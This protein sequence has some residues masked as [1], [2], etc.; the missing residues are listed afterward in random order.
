MA[1]MFID[2]YQCASS[3]FA[4]DWAEEREH[5]QRLVQQTGRRLERVNL[6]CARIQQDAQE[7][8]RCTVPD[9]AI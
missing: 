4:D 3:R 5:A 8:H 1:T 6:Q 7:A 9:F 2:G